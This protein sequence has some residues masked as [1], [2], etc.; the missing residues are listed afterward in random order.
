MSLLSDRIKK[1]GP[2]L[3][4][5]ATGGL[6]YF[7][8]ARRP[9]PLQEAIPV[10]CY[11]LVEKQSFEADLLFLE[12]NGYHTTTA[13]DLLDWIN[14]KKALAK[15]SIV[16][17]FDDGADNFYR[18]AYPLLQQYQQ[19]AV[20]FVAP[21]LHRVA[22]EEP[23]HANRPCTWE[24]L[25][26]MH[27]SGLVDLQSHT[28]E[29]RSLQTWP[30]P[31]PLTGVSHEHLE[32]RRAVPRNMYDDL[33]LARKTLEEHFHKPIQHLAWP[34]Y[35]SKNHTIDIAV[36]AGYT[37]FWTGTLPHLPIITPGH[38]PHKIVR[39]SGEFVRRLPGVGRE[40]LYKIL[41]TRYK[42]SYAKLLSGKV[43]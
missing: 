34:C 1:N 2:E 25:T 38:D 8:T 12:Q 39:I 29:H 37:A 17:T 5:L 40:S 21:G 24:E 35:Y 19:T 14:G 16:L 7:V 6:P 23:W 36:Q 13:D 42:N 26:E 11:H 15:N 18:V 4:A 30:T 32:G 31:L 28:W 10:F 22:S 27:Q 41:R 43:K 33:L 3:H 20:L 9:F